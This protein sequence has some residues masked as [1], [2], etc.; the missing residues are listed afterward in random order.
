[1]YTPS[2]IGN[3]TNSLVII[4]QASKLVDAVEAK[5]ALFLESDVLPMVDFTTE[6]SERRF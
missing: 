1:M 6:D 5:D 4:P 2:W 3:K